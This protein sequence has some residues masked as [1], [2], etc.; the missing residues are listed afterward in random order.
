[1]FWN[2]PNLYSVL[3]KDIP[4]Q[5]F[6]PF[7]MIPRFNTPYPVTPSYFTPPVTPFTPPVTPF[8]PYLHMQNFPFVPPM[9]TPP[10]TPF[11][12]YLHNQ[13][14][15]PFVNPIT[16]PMINPQLTPYNWTLPFYGAYR[17]FP[18]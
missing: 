13:P 10:V 7:G 8:P 14:F 3:F 15:T 1:M 12:P 16:N 4:Q 18:L 6:T 17:P 11:T 9:M 5:P 2:D